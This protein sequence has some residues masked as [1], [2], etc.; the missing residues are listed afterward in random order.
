MVAIGQALK[1]VTSQDA[2]NWFASCGYNFI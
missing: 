1:A 2:I